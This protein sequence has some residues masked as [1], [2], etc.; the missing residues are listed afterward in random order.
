MLAE[1]SS[2]AAPPIAVPDHGACWAPARFRKAVVIVVD[3]LRY[4]FTVPHPPPSSSPDAP[5]P[6]HHYLNALPVL[7]E[8]AAQR[9][10]HA[11]LRP[12]IA[13]PPTTTLQRLK[14]LTTGTLPTFVDAG[15]NFAGTA[16]DEDNLIAQLHAAGR[17]VVHLGDDTW[18]ALFPGRFDA[19][20]TRAYDS[21]NVWDLH[22]VDDG[23]AAHLFPLLERPGEWDVVIAHFLGLD[24]AGHRYGP[25]H[26]ATG[27]KLRQMDGLL[28]RARD[29]IDDDTLLVVLGDHG[30]DAKGDHGGDSFD[31][32]AAALWLYSAR[33]FFGRANPAHVDPPQ[34]AHERPC[35]QIDL[36]PTLALLLGLP[37]PFNN[38]G[39]PIP[40]AFLGPDGTHVADLAAANALAAAQI[41]RYR[42]AY[43][44]KRGLGD[45]AFAGPHR[46]WA[47]AASLWR[48]GA[49]KVAGRQAWYEEAAA[50]FAAFAQ[51]H[52][53][54]CR[55]LWARFDVPSMAVGLA[56]LA[57][58]AA[59]LL[60]WA[61]LGNAARERAVPVVLRHAGYALAAG[62]VA[63]GVGF[64]YLGQRIALDGAALTLAVAPLL[65]FLA[66]HRPTSFSTTVRPPSF[67]HAL[68][69]L[70][71]LAQAVGFASNSF[72][73]WEDRQL[74]FFLATFA[75]L[76]LVAAQRQR[77]PHDRAL[78]AYHSILFLLCAR[79]AAA[80][81]LCRDEQLPRCRSTYYASATSS[82]AAPWQL[83]V[84]LAV[85]CALPPVIRG[86][87]RG[88]RS[89][90]GAAPAWLG[91]ALPAGLAGVAAYRVL[92]AADDAGWLADVVSEG[93]LKSVKVGLAQVLLAL[94]FA[95]GPAMVAWAAPCVRITA[96]TPQPN[97]APSA[98]AKPNSI[99]KS[100]SNPNPQTSL[101]RTA[102]AVLGYANAHGAHAALLYTAL[103]LG[104]ILTQKPLG[105]GA[106][107]L[108]A[109][110]T[111]SL[112]EL[113]DALALAHTAPGLAPVVLALAGGAAFFATG[114]QATLA[115]L[116]WDAAFLASRSVRYPWSPLLVL[117]NTFAG[118]ALAAAGVPV[119][120]LWKRGPREKGLLGEVARG[121]AVLVGYHAVLG[122]ATAAW[123]GYLRRHLMLYRVFSPRFMVG[124]AVLVV[125]DVVGLLVGVGSVRWSAG[126]VAE[127]FGWS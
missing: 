53:R 74:L 23:V 7:H 27:A 57:L 35:A 26:P 24:H 83:L 90:E 86:F 76:A 119:V 81:R 105:T 4:D 39:A 50:A 9:P 124:A 8:T 38:L 115:S 5:P 112:A 108:L 19:H 45:E 110:Q 30:M 34:T 82:T 37:I 12:F 89:L 79:L 44:A 64:A 92:D 125:V 31:E 127:V 58:G 69:A 59:V 117:L 96:A 15:S 106:L 72:T 97:G 71:T 49:P 121:V 51:E 103:L 47:A 66:Q 54:V 99:V 95:A 41:E 28:R 6:Q 77:A 60:A 29:A 102:V 63:V 104:A 126:S 68:A 75:V 33:P 78:G 21:F 101:P 20:R 122:L 40:E 3:A 48:A 94:A 32:V 93:T 52:L 62:S 116:Q 70:F 46:L 1:Q 109:L 42:A 85:A 84:P 22:T 91:A 25:D 16:I 56:V 11:L 55:S 10:A 2:C 14:A 61:G 98:G 36:V 87:F 120:V 17:R 13:D 113:T 118:P 65:G 80:S 100:T 67:W 114:H 88:T 123:A 73:I 18:H 43:A 111:F 107:A